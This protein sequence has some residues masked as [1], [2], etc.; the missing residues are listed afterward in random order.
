[1][2]FRHDAEIRIVTAVVD[3]QVNPSLYEVFPGLGA[4]IAHANVL[5][6]SS[7]NEEEE[8]AMH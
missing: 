3:D 7:W 6:A 2:V 1:V 4:Y 5:R 8:K